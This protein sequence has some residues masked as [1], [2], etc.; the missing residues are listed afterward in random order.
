[1]QDVT[2]SD[3]GVGVTRI[4]AILL[5]ALLARLLVPLGAVAVHGDSGVFHAPDT[6]SYLSTATSLVE[7]GR[8]A[9]SGE[10]E[11]RRTPGYPL[12][13]TIGVLAGRPE[14]VTIILQVLIGM[15]SVYGVYA[16]ARRLAMFGKPWDSSVASL[17]ALLYALDP[18]SVLYSSVLLS[19]TL[20][21]A[22]LIAHLYGLIRYLETRSLHFVGL[23]ALF[24]AAAAY[25]RPVAYFWP[26]VAAG[27]LLGYAVFGERRLTGRVVPV[28]LLVVISMTPIALWQVRNFV[29]T[30]YRGFSSIGDR[31][32][33]S[34]LGASVLAASERRPYADV[35]RRLDDELDQHQEQHDWTPTQRYEYMGRE[36]AR[37]ILSQPTTYLGIHLRGIVRALVDPGANWYLRLYRLYPTSGGLLSQTVDRGILSTLAT[38]AREQPRVL[39]AN[40]LLGLVLGGQLLLAGVGL[41]R[42]LPRPNEAVVMLLGSAVYFLVVTG[43]PAAHSR[44]RHPVMPVVCLLAGYGAAF[45]WSM[46]RHSEVQRDDS[47]AGLSTA[48]SW[49]R[50][51]RS[52]RTAK[53]RSSPERLTAAGDMA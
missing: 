29:Q 10:A 7:E 53:G 47:A 50:S 12:L 1:M 45:L 40:L 23:A 48:E 22:L 13:L 49:R 25:V 39:V 37:L 17:A 9:Q 20:F 36:G 3:R 34:Y 4:G 41:L 51:M 31:N 35:R 8:F 11:I 6:D 19:E 52:N 28:V 14:A 43:G 5:L 26:L 18:L 46:L 16:L 27:L 44:F 33:Y 2:T 30:G 32:L 42:I 24:A 15:L 38:V 21:T